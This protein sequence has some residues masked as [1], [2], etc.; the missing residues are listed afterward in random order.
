MSRLEEY[1]NALEAA[2]Q[3]GTID[4]TEFETVGDQTAGR[5][6]GCLTLAGCLAEPR[7]YPVTHVPAFAGSSSGF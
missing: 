6:A 3:L 1:L 4:E 5:L 2:R 7:T